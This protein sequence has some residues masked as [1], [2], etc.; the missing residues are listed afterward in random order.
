MEKDGSSISSQEGF[1]AEGESGE[2]PE[3]YAGESV[4]K[5]EYYRLQDGRKIPIDPLNPEGAKALLPGQIISEFTVPEEAAVEMPGEGSFE[6][7]EPQ[8]ADPQDF[9]RSL[10]GRLLK[11]QLPPSGGLAFM[12]PSGIMNPGA[13]IPATA[14][15]QSHK[16]FGKMPKLPPGAYHRRNGLFGGLC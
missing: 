14:P 7:S 13:S 15:L 9:N 10:K 4:V 11:G 12:D 1:R 16:S 6:S 8:L 2:W 3:G 5:E